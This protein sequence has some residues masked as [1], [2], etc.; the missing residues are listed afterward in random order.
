MAHRFPLLF[1][2][3][4]CRRCMPSCTD[5][6]GW[7]NGSN[8]IYPPAFNAQDPPY[9]PLDIADTLSGAPLP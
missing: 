3:I 5:P 8:D 2:L 6:P 7:L 4:K 1:Y 9:L